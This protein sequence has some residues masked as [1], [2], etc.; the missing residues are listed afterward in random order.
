MQVVLVHGLGRTPLSMFGLAAALRRAG[1]R[2]RF[3]GYLGLLE[4]VSRIV[5]R[6]ARL[7][8]SLARR[9]QP[10]GLVGHSLGGLLLRAA[11]AAVPTLK[12]H[13]L[14]CLGTPQVPPRMARWAWQWW[15]PFRVLASDCGRWLLSEQRM[16]QL[17]PL[18]GFPF[19]LVVGTAGP[20]RRW[21]P[22]GDTENDWIVT[23]DECR[24]PGVEPV[25]VRAWHGFLMDHP[26]VQH[27]I[28]TMMTSDTSHS[29]PY[30]D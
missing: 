3:F 14:I 25:R 20:R 30:R 2:T 16:A 29:T 19:T 17:P 26:A 8:H 28:V 9:N 4:S 15:P 10:V 21:L 24:L 11:V 13:H 23:V 1:H 6:L 27:L 22:L 7:L 12:I 18:H 5:L